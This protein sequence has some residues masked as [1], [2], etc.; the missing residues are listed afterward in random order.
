M[1]SL[2]EEM[3]ELQNESNM[4]MHETIQAMPERLKYYKV[5]C[6]VK[7]SQ[8]NMIHFK[9]QQTLLPRDAGTFRFDVSDIGSFAEL[10]ELINF[11]EHLS[12]TI[13]YE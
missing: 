6:R 1:K 11:D 7:P 9:G 13:T 2:V 3:R 10:D 4:R 12:I 5:E 8:D